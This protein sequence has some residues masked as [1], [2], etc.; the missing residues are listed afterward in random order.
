MEEA[1]AEA[2]ARCVGD[3]V[4]APDHIVPSVFDRAVVEQV[5]L[6]TANAAAA[7]GVVRL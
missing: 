5:A 1:A 2:I 7:D 3:D 4:L 6:A